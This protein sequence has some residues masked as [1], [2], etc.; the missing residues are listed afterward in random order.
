M[1]FVV[2]ASFCFVFT[3][4]LNA[5]DAPCKDVVTTNSLM[6]VYA[7]IARAARIQGIVRFKVALSPDGRAEVK[8]L[9][10]LPFLAGAATTYIEGR[11]HYWPT[12]NEHTSC[13]YTTVVEYRIITPESDYV[14]NFFRVTILGIDHTLVEVQPIKPTCNDCSDD[15]CPLDGMAESKPLI[16]PAMARAAHV[17]GDISARV[18]FDGK[19]KVTGIDHLLG[20]E[21]LKR[22]TEDYLRSWQLKSVPSYMS[23]C[24]T[25]VLIEYRLTAATEIV[26]SDSHV[27]KADP[28]HI[29]VEDHPVM[30]VDPVVEITKTKRKKFLRLF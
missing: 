17:E 11:R 10:G 20:P 25:T 24:H 6:P 16:Y 7:P 21:M 30:T 8:L 2:L 28:T 14:N 15:T 12:E 4:S 13:S 26:A 23:S 5:Q 1:R 29:L 9:D 18:A 19:G 22:P 27:F 3:L